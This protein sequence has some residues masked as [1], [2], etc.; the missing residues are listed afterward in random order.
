MR[1]F[2]IAGVVMILAA[3]AVYTA[4]APVIPTLAGAHPGMPVASI[5]EIFRHF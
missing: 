3:V 2:L 1:R 5:G 4:K